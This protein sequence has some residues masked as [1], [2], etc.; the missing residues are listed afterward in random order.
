MNDD[1]HF[2]KYII[3]KSLCIGKPH[4]KLEKKNKFKFFIII[5]CYDEYDYLFKTLD[6]INNQKLKLLEKTLVVIVINNSVDTNARVKKNN[7]KTYN[8]LIKLQFSFEFLHSFLSS[9]YQIF[10]LL[11]LL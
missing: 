9:T 5:P 11:Q 7:Q 2:H 8:K 4:R 6:S 10:S 1:I 3:K